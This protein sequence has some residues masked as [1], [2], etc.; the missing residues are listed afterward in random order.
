MASTYVND[1]RLNELGTGDGSGTWGTTTNTNLELIAEALGF[2]TEAITTN[3]DT[4]SSVVADGATDPARHMYIKYTGALDSNC[5]ITISPNTISRVHLIENATTDSGSSGPYS[6]IISQGSGANVT[7]PNGQVAMV[8][9]DG[10]GS[11]AAVVN[12]L[13]NPLLSGDITASGTLSAT[14]DTSSGDTAAI[15]FTSTEGIIIT[16]QGSTNDVTIKNDADTQVMG[17][18]TGTTTSVFAGVLKTDDTTDA[19]S[20]TD[21]S[22]QTDGGLSVAKDAVIGDDLKLLSDASVIH[23]GADSEITLTHVHD[24]GLIL[25]GTTPTLTIGD[26]GAEDTKI[27][28][29]GNAQDFYVGLDDSEDDLV[30]GKGSTLGTTPAVSIDE[31]LIVTVHN[32]AVSGSI[33]DEGNSGVFD[34]ADGNN[35]KA[36]PTSTVSEL[37]FSNPTA[38]QSGNVLFDNSAGATVSAAH[39]SVAINASALTSLSTAGVYFLT[40]YCTAASG[41]NTILV[42]VSGALT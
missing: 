1:L 2:A 15:G 41:N 17:V 19:T 6:I 28:F 3:A 34:L 9:L 29:D 16:G 23:F 4:H 13:T 42:S 5:T 11:G 12:A 27:V 38:G 14:G 24:T 36:T 21:G 40:Y 18:L 20:T 32:R 22:L 31:N 35:F 26:A 39:A 33:V 37:T 10:A 25:G 7:I 8:Y 30:I